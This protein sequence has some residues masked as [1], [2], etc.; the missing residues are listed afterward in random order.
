MT[1]FGLCAALFGIAVA[2]SLQST[3]AAA[4]SNN[5]AYVDARN[6]SNSN[7][8]SGCPVTNPCADLNTA[9]SVITA[10]GTVQILVGGVF[11]PVVL[12]HS[13]NIFGTDPDADT[14]IMANSSASA[15]CIGA[16]A[17]TCGNNGFGIE[18]AAGANDVVKLSHLMV[19]AGSS[20]NG[21]LKIDSAGSVSDTHSTFYGNATTANPIVWIAPSGT[22]NL[23]VYMSHGEIAFNQAGGGLLVAPTGSAIA[24]L[25]FNHMEVHNA[26]FGIRTDSSGLT[27]AGSV[28]TNVS[29]S[30]FFS[31]SGSAVTAF[32]SP[33]VG[34][35]GPVLGV[36]N[37]VNILNTAGPAVNS[38]GAQSTVILTN[39]TV[40]GNQT[41]VRV[42]NGATLYTSLNNTIQGNGTEVVGTMTAAPLQ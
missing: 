4:D 10:G 37:T 7:S 16:A 40:A 39:S 19:T 2:S 11:A 26:N 17:G 27:T 41:G 3:P 31:F 29:E 42:I 5:F 15:G 32:S 23:Q 25:H 9:L 33:T 35:S 30:E 34:G 1:K 6:G 14:V 20:G 18:I 28:N 36:Y 38:N 13:V 24:K 12:T 8:S 22:A 21:A